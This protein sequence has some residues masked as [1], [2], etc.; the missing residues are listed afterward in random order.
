MKFDQFIYYQRKPFI[1]KFYES[2]AWK[3]VPDPF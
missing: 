3:L 1:K 2:V